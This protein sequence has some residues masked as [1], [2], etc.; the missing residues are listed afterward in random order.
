MAGS[1]ISQNKKKH[2]KS[3]VVVPDEAG[4]WFAGMTA[5]SV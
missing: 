4:R 2:M 5:V 3:L 1:D